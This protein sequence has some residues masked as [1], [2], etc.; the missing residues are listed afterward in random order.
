MK[1][2]KEINSPPNMNLLCSDRHGCASQLQPSRSPR[3]EGGAAVQSN[4][5][6]YMLPS[7]ATQKTREMNE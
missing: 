4:P 1:T 3:E 7:Q 2:R 6:T 5:Y